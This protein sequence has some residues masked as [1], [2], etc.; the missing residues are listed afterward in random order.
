MLNMADLT[1]K[2]VSEP[3]WRPSQRQQP[4]EMAKYQQ[5]VNRKFNINLQ[6]THHLQKW[7]IDNPHDFWLDLYTYM[8]LTPALPPSLKTAYDDSIPMSLIPQFFPGLQINYAEN[9]LFA[10]PNPDAPALIAIRE[11]QDIYRENGEV[12]TWGALREQVRLVASAFRNSGIKR[13]DRVA[14]LVA[15]SNWAVVLFHATASIGAIFTVISPELGFEGCVS[16][17]QQVSPSILFVDSHAIYKGKAT[18]T[19]EKVA[20]I[21][22][23][24]RPRP[25]VYVIPVVSDVSHEFP[26]ID[27]FLQKS[28]SQDKLCFTRVPFNYP[29]MICYSSGTTGAPKCIVHHHGT[30]IQ[31]KKTTLLHDCLTL[32]DVVMQ[33]SSTS[34]AVFYGMCGRLSSG[35]TLVLYNGNPLYPDA[36]QLLRICERYK[37]AYLG[38]SPRLLLEIEMSGTTPK[39]EFDLSSLKTVHTTG[40]PLSIEQ[41][42]WFYRSFPP[43]IQICNIAAGTETG[44]AI[45]AMDPSGPIYAGELQI[46]SLG[47]DLDVADEV[48]GESIADTG[49]AGELVIRK[50][51]PSMPC[52]FWGDS[53]GSIYKASYF[54]RYSNINVWAQHDW[55]RKNPTTGGYVIHGR[56]DGV[57]S[58]YLT[59][60]NTPMLS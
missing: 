17:L 19:A 22:L 1:K 10:N 14:A 31:M 27:E 8:N 44:A 13:G 4:T 2:V 21:V 39:T 51:F 30:C 3:V 15:T 55:L 11:G 23:E 41:Y 12:L 46:A 53:S 45:I 59:R 7:S 24:L 5:H 28:S 60:A 52:F 29:L 36:K 33:Y 32:G 43:D 48:T 34:W 18:S 26:V 9:M 35:V 42:K 16:R 50:P 38:S 6:N 56:S 40:A 20:K 58:K 54:E 47:I 57:L 37:V 49:R 25:Q